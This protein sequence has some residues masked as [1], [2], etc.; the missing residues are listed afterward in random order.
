MV[1]APGL[2]LEV[3]PLLE[4]V[5]LGAPVRVNIQLT[6]NSGA[7]MEAPP[8][9][10]LGSGFVRGQ[11]TDPSGT[12]RTFSPLV[13]CVDQES[14][15]VLAPGKSLSNSLTLLRGGQGALF[16]TP[17]LHCI[18]VEARWDL[19]GVEAIVTGETVVIVTSAVDEGH[20]STALKL[21]TTPDAQLTLV[22]GGDHLEKGIEAIQAAL[23]NSVLRPHYAHIEAK[24]LGDPFGK[25]K[26][27][28]NAAAAL[29]DEATVMSPDEVKR[30]AELVKKVGAET[31]SAKEIASTLK[32]RVAQ[33]DVS[34]SIR[35]MV[36]EL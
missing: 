19:G 14:P 31:A 11:V 4:A 10:S 34:A 1:E 12:V 9:L 33:Q 5:P 18:R 30:A 21:L 32:A 35:K 8:S 28:L 17:G 2:I 7:P 13:L 16:P 29:I 20:A 27:N 6:N 24:R 23:E 15:L 36:D 25:R 26:A 22:L 3:S